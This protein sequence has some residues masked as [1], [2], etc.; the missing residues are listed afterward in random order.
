MTYRDY[1]IQEY[2]QVVLSTANVDLPFYRAM[3][4]GI[5]NLSVT[6]D[7]FVVLVRFYQSV[8]EWE[9][10]SIY[11]IRLIIDDKQNRSG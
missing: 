5:T 10:K 6:K 11:G 4:D 7:E 8:Y 9:T 3:A 2:G 1:F